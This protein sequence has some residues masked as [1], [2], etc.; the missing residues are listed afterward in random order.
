M[1][2]RA[3]ER[4]GRRRVSR[5]PS[6][7]YLCRATRTGRKAT[8]RPSHST[9]PDVRGQEAEEEEAEEAEEEEEEEE[10]GEVV[11]CDTCSL[12]TRCLLKF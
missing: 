9:S 3:C 5:P 2:G 7:D 4:G 11:C 8:A 6:K 1:V 10:D 12:K